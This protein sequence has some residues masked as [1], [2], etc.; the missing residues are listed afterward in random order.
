MKNRLFLS[1]LFIA[2]FA[3]NQ[4]SDV[5][6]LFADKPN[7]TW[8]EF[9][10]K[11]RAQYRDVVVPP[12]KEFNDLMQSKEISDF[13]KSRVSRVF[14]E[15]IIGYDEQ[16]ESVV[17]NVDLLKAA[18]RSFDCMKIALLRL[19]GYHMYDKK[20]RAENIQKAKQIDRDA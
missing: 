1:M 16:L 13:D 5:V 10:K 20:K 18:S 3:V 8:K 14:S 12:V 17:Y 6:G 2:N 4:A 9:E 7:V 19:A 15:S 11:F